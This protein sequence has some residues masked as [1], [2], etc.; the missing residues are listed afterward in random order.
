MMQKLR[1]LLADIV[2]AAVVRSVNSAKLFTLQDFSVR[3]A[4]PASTPPGPSSQNSVAP[5]AAALR[6]QSSHSTDETTCLTSAALIASGVA[7]AWPVLL[8]K[9]VNF[10]AAKGTPSKN[11]ANAAR[12]GS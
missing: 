12:A 2:Q 1:V 9:T 6:M 7:T 11:F 8:V 4:S 3:R 10:G 5:A